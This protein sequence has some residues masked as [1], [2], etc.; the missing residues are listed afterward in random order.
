MNTNSIGAVQFL[1]SDTGERTAAVIPI[2]GW[3]AI[4]ALYM[5]RIEILE[6]IRESFIELKE[7]RAGRLEARP[8]E[9]LWDE[10]ED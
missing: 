3:K 4:E 9:E 8:I 5:E 6:D 7:I 1:M 10:L 2:E